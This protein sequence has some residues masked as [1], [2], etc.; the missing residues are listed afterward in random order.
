MSNTSDYRRDLLAWLVL[1]I[2]IVFLFLVKPAVAISTRAMYLPEIENLKPIEDKN[3]VNLIENNNFSNYLLY[4][5]V[6]LITIT[7]PFSEQ[8]NIFQIQ[9]DAIDQAKSIAA[10]AGANKLLVQFMAVLPWFDTKQKVLRV[11]A[12]ALK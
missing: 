9:T 2:S 6:G 7:M 3:K 11:Q 1:T 10:N 8:N 4:S 12:L 5:K